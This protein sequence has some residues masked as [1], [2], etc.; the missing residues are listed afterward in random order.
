MK[1]PV[2]LS[3]AAL[4]AIAVAAPACKGK[5]DTVGTATATSAAL[6]SGAAPAEAAP[7]A[8][9]DTNLAEFVS[10][11]PGVACKSISA[12]KND[13]VKVVTGTTAMMVVG[14]GTL[15]KPELA[16]DVKPIDTALKA[17]KR[18]VLTEAE[19]ATVG[20]TVFK[21]VGL[22]AEALAPR[23]GKTMAYDAAKAGAC[24]ASLAQAPSVCAEEVK[25]ATSPKFSEIGATEKDV[26]ASL[27][28][29]SK[30]CEDVLVGLVEDGAACEVDLECK[31]KK[32]KCRDASAAAAPKGGKKAAK[33]A[34]AAPSAAGKVCQ[35]SKY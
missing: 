8:A 24:L 13:K 7:V 20:S 23:I 28:T 9:K 33:G 16:K 15:D 3:F 29:F 17:E 19:C 10:K 35:A 18:A 6:P 4:L 27:E 26:K 25:I 34:K 30:P 1:S 32:S 5:S 31:G 22:D 11:A 12:C 21:V 14:L 2:L